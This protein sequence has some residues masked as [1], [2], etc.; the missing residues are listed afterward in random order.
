MLHHTSTVCSP[1][2]CRLIAPNFS[3]VW[4][5]FHL[6]LT[7]IALSDVD[8]HFSLMLVREASAVEYETK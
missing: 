2:S 1:F 6:F 5:A 7:W 3:S 8:L 4:I